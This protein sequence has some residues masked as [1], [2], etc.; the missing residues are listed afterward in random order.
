MKTA[1]KYIELKSS[2]HTDADEAWIAKVW[3][4]SSGKTI[5][6]NDI[7]LKRGQGADSNHFNIENGDEYWISGVKKRETNRHWRGSIYIEESLVE[8][9]EKHTEGK[10]PANIIPR[11]DRLKPDIERFHKLEN[12]QIG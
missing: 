5:Y 7:A 8:W 3:L 10:C 12:D 9:Y 11:P 4:S 2:H 6:F 1:I